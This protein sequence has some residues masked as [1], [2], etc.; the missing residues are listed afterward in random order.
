MTFTRDVLARRQAASDRDRPPAGPAGPASL[1]QHLG[2]TVGNRSLAR[3]I[4]SEK[5]ARRPQKRR[6]P[7]TADLEEWA[8]WPHRTH[9]HWKRLGT[10]ERIAV[11]E[12]MRRRYGK[13][14]AD[15]FRRHAEAGKP[16]LDARSCEMPVCMPDQYLKQGYKV[17]DRAQYQIW[18]VH[19]SGRWRYL[20]GGHPTNKP[21]EDEDPSDVEP[22]IEEPPIEEPPPIVDPPPDDLLRTD[23][24]P[25][26]YS[27]PRP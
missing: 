21:S 1:V 3:L 19:P 17:A 10:L 8:R 11:L 4:A 2:T 9:Q 16:D 15:L 13:D 7:T 27:R 12:R 26:D 20:F 14:F 6:D 22:P 24:P 23:E 18:L 25:I 5:L